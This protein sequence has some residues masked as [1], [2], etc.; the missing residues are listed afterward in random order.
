MNNGSF[1][2]RLLRRQIEAVAIL[3]A[4]IG[5][6]LI[7]SGL[8]VIEPYRTIFL[9]IGTGLIASIATTILYNY[10]SQNAAN[11]ILDKLIND[12]T[13]SIVETVRSYYY[14]YVPEKLFVAGQQS[15]SD[16]VSDV[17]YEMKK[18]D[19]Y[20]FKGTSGKLSAYRI[21]KIIR[22][23]NFRKVTFHLMSPQNL[24]ALNNKA[25]S[26]LSMMNLAIDNKNKEEVINGILCETLSTIAGLFYYGRGF[27]NYIEIVF[28]KETSTSRIELLDN[29]IYVS[30]LDDGKNKYAET[31]KFK[32]D[33]KFYKLFAYNLYTEKDNIKSENKLNI[34]MSTTESDVLDFLVRNG[35]QSLQELKSYLSLFVEDS[36]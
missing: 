20:Y 32:A 27:S 13:Q 21:T 25:A 22:E 11:A 2:T 28:Q 26:K 3:I 31:L 29:A 10:Y 15:G 34:D 6:T 33:T 18:S 7:V 35:F 8:I 24:Q 9:S 1:W 12:K 14:E 16:F 19:Y 5:L 23:N 4:G 36:F 17:E 30:L